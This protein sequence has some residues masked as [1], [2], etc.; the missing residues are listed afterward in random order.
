MTKGSS[1]SVTSEASLEDLVAGM[2]MSTSPSTR[3]QGGSDSASK[4]RKETDSV[5]RNA[6]EDGTSFADDISSSSSIISMTG[7]ATA[8]GD[9]DGESR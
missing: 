1:P 9:D 3:N 5:S 6:R 2:S 8:C 4:T 7:F